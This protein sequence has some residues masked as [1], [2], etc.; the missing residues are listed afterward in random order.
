MKK[1]K[2]IYSKEEA[3]KLI[4]KYYWN[5]IILGIYFGFNL[6]LFIINTFFN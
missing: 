4:K 5:G 6:A 3:Y 1:P 2:E